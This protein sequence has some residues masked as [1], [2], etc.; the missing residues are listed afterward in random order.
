MKK[1]IGLVLILVMAFSLLCPCFSAITVSAAEEKVL[2]IGNWEDY[3]GEEVI[4]NFE[5][6]TGIKVEYSTFGTNEDMYNEL[7]INP[8][9]FDLMCPSEYMIQ[10]MLMEDMLISFPAPT[11]YLNNGSSYIIDKFN[12]MGLK[13]DNGEY[14]TVGY[15]WGLLGL[16]YNPEFVVRSDME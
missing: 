1:I 9:S 16:T 15:M 3:I 12:S 14:Y 6:D 4:T 5:Q 10:K 7:K 13:A 8:G 2:R 11:N